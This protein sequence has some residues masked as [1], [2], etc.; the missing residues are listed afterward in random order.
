MTGSQATKHDLMATWNK[1][2]S[3]QAVQLKDTDGILW[4]SHVF[5]QVV[6]NN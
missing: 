1:L 6:V 2:I 3:E 5:K 4:L